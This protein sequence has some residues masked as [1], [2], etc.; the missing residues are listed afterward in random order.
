M[1]TDYLFIPVAAAVPSGT[2]CVARVR[3]ADAVTT[4]RGRFVL[5]PEM[6]P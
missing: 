3:P 6:A 5:H 2:A 1:R 4:R